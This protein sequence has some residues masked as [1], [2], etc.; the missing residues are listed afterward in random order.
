MTPYC[1][2]LE[3]ESVLVGEEKIPGHVRHEGGPVEVDQSA[4]PSWSRHHSNPA[5]SSSHL[6]L[7]LHR[8]PGRLL[9]QTQLGVTTRPGVQIACTDLFISTNCPLFICWI[10]YIGKGGGG[11]AGLVVEHWTPI[12]KV[13]GPNTIRDKRV[14]A[15]SRTA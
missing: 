4:H 14:S 8:T 13:L 6:H 1:T 2:Y 7:R 11:S 15:V 5:A 3:P 10:T 12:L 9:K